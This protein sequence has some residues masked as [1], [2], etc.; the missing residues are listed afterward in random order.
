MSE[1]QEKDFQ[2]AVLVYLNKKLGSTHEKEISS[3]A[4]ALGVNVATPSSFNV[5]TLFKA[6]VDE[7]R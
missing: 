4:S 3:I 7:G 2:H 1:L 5:E 6:E